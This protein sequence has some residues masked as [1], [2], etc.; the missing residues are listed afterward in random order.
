MNCE[1]CLRSLA[2]NET[3]YR[4]QAAFGGGTVRRCEDCAMLF[5]DRW[6]APVQCEGCGRP[7]SYREDRRPRLHPSCG[8]WACLNSI[9][10]ASGR[11]RR[12]TRRVSHSSAGGCDKSS[13]T[14][15]V[16][17]RR[18]SP[19]AGEQPRHRTVCAAR[20]DAAPSSRRR[21]PRWPALADPNRDR[22]MPWRRRPCAGDPG[23]R[24]PTC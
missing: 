13:S 6:L 23:A 2:D 4:F 21:S 5:H 9:S 11:V 24:R 12:S 1:R 14:W 16:D 18:C 20:S 19:S 7:V 22:A 8:Q 15:T 10:S 17:Y 3:A